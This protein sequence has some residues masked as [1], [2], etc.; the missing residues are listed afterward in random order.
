[1][2]ASA[3]KPECVRDRAIY[4]E[5]A[6]QVNLINKKSLVFNQKGVDSSGGGHPLARKQ[7]GGRAGQAG[8]I[9]SENARATA[10]EVERC[11]SASG[12][13]QRG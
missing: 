9:L 6:S 5:P 12:S 11:P 10:R 1:M 4:A 13:S 8:P 3:K 2:E 7:P